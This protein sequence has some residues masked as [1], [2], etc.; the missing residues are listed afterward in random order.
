LVVRRKDTPRMFRRHSFGMLADVADYL[1]AGQAI[2]PERGV[3]PERDRFLD[4]VVQIGPAWKADSLDS[5]D[6]SAVHDDFIQRLS[7][8]LGVI[9]RLLVAQDVSHADFVI[10]FVV[11]HKDANQMPEPMP[12]YRPLW[13][14][15][16]VRRNKRSERFELFAKFRRA[17]G[18]QRLHGLVSVPGERNIIGR[19]IA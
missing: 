11:E 8:V 16:F 18:K 4:Y 12:G 13:L 17:S 6:F 10:V 9:S 3:V 1:D 7:V 14:I 2:G 5:T 15:I 19:A